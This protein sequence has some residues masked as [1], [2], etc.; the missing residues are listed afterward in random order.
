MADLQEYPNSIA[1]AIDKGNRREL[2][3]P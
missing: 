2:G 3:L 1:A